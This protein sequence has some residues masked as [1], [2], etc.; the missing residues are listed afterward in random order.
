M[1][2]TL[3]ASLN[4]FHNGGVRKVNMILRETVGDINITEAWVTHTDGSSGWEH[5]VDDG[6]TWIPRE[7]SVV[8]S[9]Y[10]VLRADSTP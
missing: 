1:N 9:L 4:T 2:E 6:K 5:T 10:S 3:I 8:Q 7:L